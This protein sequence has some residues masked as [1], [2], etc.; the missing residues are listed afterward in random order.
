MM[1]GDVAGDTGRQA[2]E[3]LRGYIYQI[4]ASALA[5]VS[6]QDD[7]LLHLE[8][9]EDYSVA[10]DDL[11]NARQVKATSEPMTLNTPSVAQTIDALFDLQDRN[12]GRVVNIQYLTTS[13]V[14][15][16]RRLE[17][18]INGASG[19]SYWNLAALGAPLEPLR[20][21]LLSLQID[22]RAR[23]FISG[24]SEEEL[25]RVLLSRI[26]W[27]CGEPSLDGLREQL[28]DLIVAW[29]DRRN[30]SSSNAGSIVSRMLQ[31]VLEV[32]VSKDRLLRRADLIRLFDE[33]TSV[34]VPREIFDQKLAALSEKSR[35]VEASA[36]IEP[37]S[38]PII[39]Q[40]APRR[41]LVKACQNAL[42]EFGVIWLHAGAGYGKTTI[43]G[44]AAAEGSSDWQVAR[45]RGLDAIQTAQQIRRA[46]ADARV[47]GAVALMLDDVENL[48][49]PEVRRA[50]EHLWY[51][52]SSSGLK[53][54]F[55][56]SQAPPASLRRNVQ[57]A[58]AAIKEIG[59][60][61]IEEVGELVTLHGGNPSL[62]GRYVYFGAGGGHPQLVHALILGLKRKSWPEAE[63]K[64]FPALLGRDDDIEAERADVRQRLFAEL[65]Q[66]DLVLLSRLTL[67]IGHF[68]G[69]LAK[70]LG[71][72]EVPVPLPGRVLDRLLGPWIDVVGNDRYRPSSLV[73]NLGPAALG[74]EATK[75]AH[76][77]IARFRTKGPGLEALEMDGALLNAMAGEER[78]SIEAIF[79]AVVSTGAA[80]LPMLANALPLLQSLSLTQPIF[81]ADTELSCKLRMMQVLLLAAS[82][83]GRTSTAYATFDIESKSLPEPAR[84]VEGLLGKLLL[85]TGSFDVIPGMV[86]RL[87]KARKAG[88]SVQRADD[89]DE[90]LSS[91]DGLQIMFAWQF[92]TVKNI[93]T[94]DRLL[95]ELSVLPTEE[96]DFWLSSFD[97]PGV[98]RGLAIKKPWTTVVAAG[99]SATAEMAQ[100]YEALAM[101]ARALG[102]DE[103]AAAAWETAAVIYDEDLKDSKRALDIIEIAKKQTD[104]HSWRLGRAK[105]RILFHLKRYAE[106][107]EVGE[108][109]ISSPSDS[110]VEMAYF[111]RELGIGAAELRRHP[112]DALFFELAGERARAAEMP[113]MGL[114][115]IGLSVD[116]AIARY[117]GGEKERPVTL[118]RDALFALER[119][120]SAGSFRH[121]ALRVFIPHTISWLSSTVRGEVGIDDS[122][123]PPGMNSNPNPDNRVGDLRRGDM[124]VVWLILDGIESLFG[125][126]AGIRAMLK[127]SGWDQRIPTLVDAALLEDELASALISLE[128]ASFNEK[129]VGFVAARAW[130]ISAD[131][132]GEL[133]L[134]NVARGRVP[135]L[136]DEELLGRRS[137][138]SKITL[139]FVTML[140]LQDR[141]V[142]AEAVLTRAN[143][144]L[145][146]IDAQE[147]EALRSGAI[148]APQD[149][150][151]WGAM[152]AIRDMTSSDVP[153]APVDLY[154]SCYRLVEL[155]AFDPTGTFM[156]LSLPWIAQAWG[157]VVAQR[158]FQLANP[159]TAQSAI[160]DFL[161]SDTSA[162]S[163][164][165][166]LLLDL[167]SNVRVPLSDEIVIQLRAMAGP[168]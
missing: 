39:S 31:R 136:N 121:S 77:A 30:Q 153:M 125:I 13:E 103:M 84:F 79:A 102:D 41:Q 133:D 118:L 45:F 111:L 101:K 142:D 4:Y 104:G 63:L 65:P 120:P 168:A 29:C 50:I 9:A 154:I 33:T 116:E 22:A 57:L 36:A 3:S 139:V 161:D 18:R 60:L 24:A 59:S 2:V 5:W 106:Q 108:P 38:L 144:Y 95:D 107:I 137:V 92:S 35:R 48:G 98:D 11:L 89:G 128:T 67:V 149:Q 32:I 44:M 105:S 157:K 110:N 49:A 28:E 42:I 119:A 146:I 85:M 145:P 156:R 21:R 135:R 80:E 88:F 97:H 150:A 34:S 152:G 6:L 71:E 56:S 117:R 54:L 143:T 167:L 113:D 26:E 155:A 114:M 66:D 37:L 124:D 115:A 130:K 69:E 76:S 16:E 165:G 17:D 83:S 7:A 134:V 141:L 14:G 132:G 70:T 8:L 23:T 90:S 53:L 109:L 148:S 164:I 61:S 131:D 58:E 40:L 47:S 20:K 19:L 127:S 43:A 162:E 99:G 158:S 87:S 159:R 62:F 78:E 122:A 81:P 86:G 74:P 112:T 68:D 96:K 10:V 100:S 25:R 163:R 91:V 82:G 123:V 51:G 75:A 15:L 73:T 160:N 166:R 93:E 64:T 27:R 52:K 46:A 12:Q 72:L 94:F 1:L 140:V 147:L 129:L 126:D 151:Y 138:I 55:T